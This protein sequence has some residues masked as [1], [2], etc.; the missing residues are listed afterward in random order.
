MKYYKVLFK[1]GKNNEYIYPAGVKGAVW[2]IMQNHFSEKM[3]V[4][5]TESEVVADGKAVITLTKT[6]AETLM[7]EFRES[8]P[9]PK[10]DEMTALPGE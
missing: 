8:Y 6:K 10:D 7:K 3:M 5:G 2:N 1:T 4:G 9:A